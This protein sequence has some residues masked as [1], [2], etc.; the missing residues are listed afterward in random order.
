MCTVTLAAAFLCVLWAVYEENAN[1][2][3][4]SLRP[5]CVRQE[6]GGLRVD[7]V[8]ENLILHRG[9]QLRAD[10]VEDRAF[11][12]HLAGDGV[13]DQEESRW[14]SANDWEKNDHWLEAAFP[15]ETRIGCV[16]I[17]WERTNACT[18]S[19]EISADGRAWESVAYF[20]DE[21]KERE[22]YILLESPV[23]TRYL[24]LHVTEV[25]KEEEDLS[26]YYQ[27]VSV[28]EFEAY[29]VPEVLRISK[30][31]IGTGTGRTLPIPEVPAPYAL[32]FGGA[33]YENLVRRDGTIGDTLSCVEVELG[34]VLERD[35][36]EWEL[37]GL[38]VEVPGSA[39][40]RA[41]DEGTLGDVGTVEWQGSGGGVRLPAGLHLVMEEDAIEAVKPTARLFA[42]ELNAAG[43]TAI[44]KTAGEKSDET[45]QI[46][47]ELNGDSSN[48]SLGEE[49]Y[50]IEIQR[51]GTVVRGN[52]AQGIRWGCV[53]LLKLLRENEGE[54]PLGRMRD[55]PRYRVRGFG[56]DVGRRPISM[57]LLHRMVEELSKNK[58][59]TLQIH[60]NDNQII[61]QSEYDGTMEGARELYAG[62]RL[63]SEMRNAE[64]EGITSQDLFY[65]KEEFA[66]FVEEARA[67]GVEVVPEIDTPA[68]SLAMTRIFPEWGMQGNP[69][70]ADCLDLSKEGAVQLG[71]E[72]WQE[73]LVPSEDGKEPAFAACTALHLGMDE[74]FGDGKDYL[75]YLKEL[76]EYVGFLASDKRLRIWGSL[77]LIGGDYS[78]ISRQL[79]MHI[80]DTSWADPAEMYA[81]GFSIINSQSSALYLIPG[82]GYDWLDLDFLEKEWMPNVFWTTQRQWELPAWSDRMLGAC[83][84][85]WNDWAS[86]NGHEITED[87]LY[88]RFAEPLP[89]IA[90]KLW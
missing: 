5:A 75:S 1:I 16:R 6:E 84:M 86:L 58:M 29:D 83:Y 42:D 66:Q 71:K 35:G 74:Y 72:L 10:S 30:P 56:I 88:D 33:D 25:R 80:W 65:T 22:Q 62:F 21:P 73:Y 85:M 26:L 15:Q 50:E 90:G 43:R 52:T 44:L 78:D 51:D 12:A 4:P 45:Y 17:Y 54:L 19:L 31:C 49:G 27:N 77:S 32:R 57:E 3:Q 67:Y 79:E 20:Q 41:N 34:F 7:M 38:R 37:P 81:E 2:D 64:G 82:G 70:S 69:E 60:L 53:T 46:R 8:S 87:G 39:E 55:Y 9:V 28:L 48:N 61:A 47:L 11:A 23:T 40:K 59:N 13:A 68:H 36:M 14:S 18:Y 89:V 76:S 63:E 24:R